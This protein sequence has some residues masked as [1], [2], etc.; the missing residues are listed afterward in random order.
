MFSPIIRDPKSGE[1]PCRDQDISV[2]PKAG[3]LQSCEWQ[4]LQGV[5]ATELP[6]LQRQ[7]KNLYVER[8]LEQMEIEMAIV[9]G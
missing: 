8:L 2:N 6:D 5:W 9:S 1:V 3:R 4:A 7:L